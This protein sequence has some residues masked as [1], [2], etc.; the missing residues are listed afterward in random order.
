VI[1]KVL[2]TLIGAGPQASSLPSRP[3]NPPIYHWRCEC[4]AH[5]RGADIKADA[6]FNAQR[7][8]SRQEAS[9][10]TPEVYSTELA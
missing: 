4:G 5:S 9:H 1:G 6:E 10:P 8:L 7:H 2:R 3:F